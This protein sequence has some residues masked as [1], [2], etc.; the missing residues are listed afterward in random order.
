MN[1]FLTNRGQ[2]YGVLSFTVGIL[3]SIGACGVLASHARL[4]SQ[5]RDTAV[6][7]GTQLPQLKSTVSLL[8]ASVEAERI[9]AEQSLTA[10]EEQASVYVLPD[11]SPAPRTVKTLQEI[12]RSLSDNGDFVLEKLT[13]DAVPQDQGN[14]KTLKARAVIRGSFQKTARLLGVLGFGGDMVVRDTL[15]PAVQEE[16]LRQIEATAPLSLKR[17][18]EFLYTDLMQ[19]AA[20]PDKNE[21]RML[22]DIPTAAVS[23]IRAT[24]L[25]AGL[26]SVRSAFVGIASG[27]FEKGLWPMPLMNVQTVERNGDRWEIEFLVFSRS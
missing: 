8:S 19:Y 11:G 3:L 27:L 14:F 25:G 20:N 2:M 1:K 15:S 10:R 4:F 5:K 26:A 18:E 6:M 13:F 21:Q 22:E 24:L 16:F 17:A 23:D 9:F 12:S 7:I